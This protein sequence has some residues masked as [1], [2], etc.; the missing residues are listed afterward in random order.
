M[1]SRKLTKKNKSICKVETPNSYKVTV[2]DVYNDVFELSFVKHQYSNLRVLI[3][4]SYPEEFGECK[5][6]GLCGTCHVKIID[7]SL[8]ESIET[9][10]KIT[11]KNSYN[12]DQTSRLACK[13]MLDERIDT[14]IFKII[15][16]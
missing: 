1:Y 6:R 4:N 10:E 15:T 2:T 14:M 5:G 9:I 13:I 8:N 3:A 11:L 16:N 7:G 12:T